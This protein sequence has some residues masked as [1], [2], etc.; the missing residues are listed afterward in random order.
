MIEL[1]QWFSQYEDIVRQLFGKRIRFIGIQGSRGRGE[2]GPDSDIDMVLILDRLN[3]G[4]LRRYREAVH[5]LP[6]RRLLCGFLSGEEE[7]RLWTPAE[8]FQFYHDTKPL[9]GT[10]DDL[11][12]MAGRE[13]AGQAV[14]TGACTL[15]HGCAHNVVH[16]RSRE[17]LAELY[18]SAGFTLRAK[19]FLETGTYL[20]KKEELLM[21]L[22]GEDLAVLKTELHRKNIRT[23]EEF[24]EASGRLFSWAGE[25]LRRRV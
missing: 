22:S 18:K 6:E 4:D 23:D 14:L 12:P 8:L 19:Y 10:L 3:V 17:V 21:A 11:A 25:L 20:S 24:E 5:A 2:A 15:Y 1:E 16:G 13:A 7:L 9:Y